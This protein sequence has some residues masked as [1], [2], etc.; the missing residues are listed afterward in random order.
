MKKEQSSQKLQSLVRE[1]GLGNCLHFR[2][3]FEQKED[4]DG[5]LVWEN[6]Q[7]WLCGNPNATAGEIKA[8]AIAELDNPTEE[9]INEINAAVDAAIAE[10]NK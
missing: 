10:E 6:N 3:G 5:N 7:V 2:W 4:Q 9:Q 1:Q 8:A